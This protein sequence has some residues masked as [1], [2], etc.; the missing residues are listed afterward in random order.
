LHIG[1]FATT[2]DDQITVRVA[3]RACPFC[4]LATDVPHERQEGCI[5]ALHAEIMRMRGLLQ[6]LKSPGLALQHGN[7]P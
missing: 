3:I 4:G 6:H 2:M 5:E 7:E 1:T